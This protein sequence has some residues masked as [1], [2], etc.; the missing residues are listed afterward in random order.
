LDKFWDGKNLSHSYFNGII[1]EQSFLFD[2]AA[3]VTAISMLFENDASWSSMMTTLSIYL[4][5]FKIDGKWIESWAG[6][7]Q[8]VYASWLD[9]PVPSS[10]SLAELGLAR[11]ALL[12]GKELLLKEYREPFKS[13]F[14]NI[15]VMMNNGLFHLFESK[16]ILSWN[17]LPVNSIRIIGDHETDCFRGTCRPLEKQFLT[18]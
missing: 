4:E 7:F 10:V 6:D 18:E 17:I 11:V 3:M 5:S 13:D 15:T 8:Q 16:K 1:Q 14:Y 2:A 9:H 12:T